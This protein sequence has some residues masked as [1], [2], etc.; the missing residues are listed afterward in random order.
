[1]PK[2]SIIIPCWNKYKFTANCLKDLSLLNDVEIIVV[3]NGSTDE[4]YESLK[5]NS[6]IIY[7]KSEINGGFAYACNIGYNLSSANIVCFLN[8]DVSVR[9]DKENWIYILIDKCKEFN[10]LVGPTMGQLNSD[11]DFIQEQ[12]SYLTGLSYM[13][14]WCLAA[15]KDIWEKLIYP[16]KNSHLLGDQFNTQIFTE[17]YFMYFEDTDLSFK[18]RL[19][20][21]P[22]S[23][24]KL[25]VVHFKRQSS[26]QLNTADLYT[27]AR[28]K[29]VSNWKDKIKLLKRD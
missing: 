29:F 22:F 20:D 6:D 8:N 21:I 3:D 16:R 13:S 28:R 10:G 2:I 18:A 5:N 15:R 24:V 4:T 17:E 9:S 19:L 1:M 11:L 26:S 25:P 27:R 23:V 12:D 7:F 14:G